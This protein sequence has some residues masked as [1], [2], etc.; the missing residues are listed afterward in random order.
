MMK[1][2]RRD[3]G[4]S[5]LEAA[6]ILP[7]LLILALGTVEFGFAFV[8][9]LSVANASRTGARIG[10]AAGVT[11]TADSV[12]LGAVGQALSDMDSSVVNAVWIYDADATG[13]PLDGCT[14]G[15]EGTCT[16]T[17][18]YAPSGG[19][20]W[21]C[22]NGCPWTPALRDNKLPGLDRVGVR[23]IFTHSWLTSFLPLPAGPWMDDSVFQLEP[24]QG[25]G[26]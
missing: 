25:S 9:W 4:T 7:I 12:I 22:V 6:I 11:A 16:T 23:V 2:L 13:N 17:N 5:T 19:S 21:S 24:A 26:S 10:S 8:D 18:V 20:G 14:I 1:F 3:K 15:S